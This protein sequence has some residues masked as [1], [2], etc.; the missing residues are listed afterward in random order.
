MFSVL[1]SS[2]LPK[3][4]LQ[5][6][7]NQMDSVSRIIDNVSLSSVTVLLFIVYYVK[8]CGK[9]KKSTVPNLYRRLFKKMSRPAFSKV[10]HCVFDSKKQCLLPIT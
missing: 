2:Q 6:T 1:L 4:K 8:R 3:Y 5:A 10:G 9:K 7:V